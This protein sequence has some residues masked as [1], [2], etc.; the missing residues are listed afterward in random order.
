MNKLRGIV[1]AG[2]RGTWYSLNEREIYV[3]DE[4]KT[5]YLFEHEEYGDEAACIIALADGTPVVEYVYNGWDDL[6]TH[7]EEEL[8]T[9]QLLVKIMEKGLESIDPNRLYERG[10]LKDKIE[11]DKKKI[12]AIES[13]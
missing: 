9:L 2:H 3:G 13:L 5:A 11:L 4:L 10:L 1:I 6:K 7:L 12:A 8:Y